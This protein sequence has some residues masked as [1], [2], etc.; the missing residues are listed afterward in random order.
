M[1]TINDVLSLFPYKNRAGNGY[2]VECPLHEDETGSLSVTLKKNKRH[3]RDQIFFHC[4][5]GCLGTASSPNRSAYNQLLSIL[6]YSHDDLCDKVS[7]NGTNGNGSAWKLKR[8]HQ[9]KHAAGTL[10]YEVLVWETPQGKLATP[11]WKGPDGRWINGTREGEYYLVPHYDEWRPVK[12]DTPTQYTRQTWPE[13]PLML[14]RWIEPNGACS[15]LSKSPDEILFIVEGE[16]DVDRLWK[17]GLIATSNTGGANRKWKA[18]YSKILNANFIVIIPDDDPPTITDPATGKTKIGLAGQKHAEEIRLSIAKLRPDIQV[19]VLPL[20]NRG[21]KQDSSDWFNEG[22]TADELKALAREALK[23]TIPAPAPTVPPT[24]PVNQSALPSKRPPLIDIDVGEHL[25]LPTLNALSWQAITEQNEPPSLFLFGGSIIRA[26]HLEDNSV[27]VESVNVDIMRHHLSKMANWVRTVTNKKTGDMSV[28]LSKPPVDVTRDVIAS[29][30]VPLPFFNRV[31]TVPVFGPDGTLR[32]EPGYCPQS[33][34]IYAPLKGYHSLP[35]PDV[36]TA[37]DVESAN[38]LI[39]DDLLHDFPF[40]EYPDGTTPD[41]DNAVA[42]FLLPFVRDM[43]D[44]PTPL[45][46]IEASMHGSGKGLLATSLLYPGLGEIAGSPQPQDEGELR[47]MITS[48]LLAGKPLIYLDNV[49]MPLD[50]GNFAAAL[51]LKIWDD[52]ILGA[53]ALSNAKIKTIWLATGNNVSM[54]SETTRRTIRIRLTPK[55]DDPAARS[56][57]KHDDLERW[58]QEHRAELVQAA[59]IIVRW[60]IQHGMKRPN[61]RNVGSFDHWSRCL[62]WILQCAGYESFLGNYKAL[63]DGS[64]IERQARAMFCDVWFDWSQRDS[65]RQRV[66]AGDLLSIANGIDGLDLRGNTD[67]GKQTS[68]G[69]YL[70]ANHEVITR[71]DEDDESKDYKTRMYKIFRNGKRK[72]SQLYSI[73]LVDQF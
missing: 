18:E 53:S 72:G 25:D 55:T 42:L 34:V 30:S 26:K 63:Q 45:H 24:P 47:K 10:A 11:R 22:H 43:I 65:D 58:I 71:Y 50:S 5:A 39:C 6:G 16:K 67:K 4:Q 8:T 31:T 33:G 61:L 15:T 70:A 52:R 3:N 66:G 23:Q 9:Y 57:F 62:G 40:S 20:F 29:Q 41:R 69:K 1:K 37:R 35:V 51:T 32:T 14:Y 27:L 21:L 7:T 64:D 54:S 60:A 13:L 59:H 46:L 49:S 12:P 56:G 38:A 19:A 36:V 28:I 73:E 48:K 44:G 68:L 2:L 17:E